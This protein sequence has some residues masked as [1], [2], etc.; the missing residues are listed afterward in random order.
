M[1]SDASVMADASDAG[2]VQQDAPPDAM[3]PAQ[4]GMAP[5]VASYDIGYINDI[6]IGPNVRTLSQL[7]LVVNRST[8]P[9]ALSMVSVTNF[10]DDSA[11]FDWTFAESTMSTLQL[12]R[13][14]AAGRLSADAAAQVRTVVTE[15]ID[16]DLLNFGMQFPAGLPAGL[17]LHAE[18]V[19]QVQAVNI[20]VPFV[21]HVSDTGDVV[22]NSARR[23]AMPL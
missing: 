2:P 4:D 18:A 22:F 23:I 11:S 21:I 12:A 6:T 17:E 19:I 1:V 16:D 10:D 8:D 14:R 15:P 13:G 7:L 20:T 5:P 9:V 3:A